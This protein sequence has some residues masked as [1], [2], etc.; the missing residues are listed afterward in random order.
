MRELTCVEQEE[1]KL[2]TIMHERERKFQEE[3]EITKSESEKFE[4]EME[5]ADVAY[6]RSVRA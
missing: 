1:V 3:D 4:I 2:E 5:K 6:D